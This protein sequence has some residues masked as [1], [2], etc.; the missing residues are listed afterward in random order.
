[1]ALLL[2]CVVSGFELYTRF[3]V[4][5]KTNTCGKDGNLCILPELFFF[6]DGSD[7][8]LPTKVDIP[9]NKDPKPCFFTF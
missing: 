1:M 6:K 3:N 8:E 4:H 2:D 7:I 9:L 5:F